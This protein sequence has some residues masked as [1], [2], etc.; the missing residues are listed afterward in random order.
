MIESLLGAFTLIIL[1]YMIGSVRIIDQGDE[2]LVQRLGQYKRTLKPGLNFVIP[3]MDTVLVETIREQLLDIDPQQVLTKDNVPIEIDAI[4]FWRILELQKAYY[5][6]EDLE[7]ALKQLVITNLRGEIGRLS[8]TE[9]ISSTDRINSELRRP[10]DKAAREWGIEVIRVEVQ[11]VTLSTALRASLEQEQI[12]KSEK[13]AALSRTEATVKSIEELARALQAQPNAQEVLR[14]LV[15]R[16]YV[17]ASLEIG[18][19]DNSKIVFMDPKALNEAITDLIR[20]H[21][22]DSGSSNSAGG[23]STN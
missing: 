12:A 3:F 17:N 9:A 18:K 23:N 15:A 10:L 2:A 4:I 22:F 11:A 7:E 19:S 21:E 14:Y 1:G 16:D 20:P 5:A 13:N 6:V 8:L